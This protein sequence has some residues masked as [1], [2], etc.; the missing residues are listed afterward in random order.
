M[1]QPAVRPVHPAVRISLR[2]VY[3]YGPC[4]KRRVLRIRRVENGS[5]ILFL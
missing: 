2:H 3:W 1:K 4:T 5:F